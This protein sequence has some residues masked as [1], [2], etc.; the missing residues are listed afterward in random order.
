MSI[1]CKRIEQLLPGSQ[2]GGNEEISAKILDETLTKLRM[3]LYRGSI[4]DIIITIQLGKGSPKTV[5]PLGFIV[6]AILYLKK[7]V[8]NPFSLNFK[9][10]EQLKIFLYQVSIM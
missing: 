5:T 9:G 6:H 10:V 1:T 3:L 2:S 4:P 8:K 7:T